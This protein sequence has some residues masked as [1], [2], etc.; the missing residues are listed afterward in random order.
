MNQERGALLSIYAETPLHAGSGTGLGAVDLPI[1]RE[2]MSGLPM[3][4]GSGIKGALYHELEHRLGKPEC[5]AL[6][7]P[8]PDKKDG[9]PPDYAGALSISDARLMLF[10]ARTVWGGWAWLTSPMI[11]ERLVR[12]LRAVGLE[13]SALEDA[14]NQAWMEGEHGDGDAIV[15][16][17]S[18]VAPKGDLFIED[19]VY[20]AVKS[21]AVDTLAKWI[22]KHVFPHGDEPLR[23]DKPLRS[24]EYRPFRDR[25]SG[26]LAIVSDAELR[27]LSKQATEV[28]ARIRIAPE[29]GTVARG[30]LWSEEHLPAE[31]V[32]W[33][34]AFVSQD[35]RP[36]DK[37]Q[38]N[39]KQRGP[40]DLLQALE[41]SVNSAGRIR[42]G[43]D[44]TVGRGVAAMRML[45]SVPTAPPEKQP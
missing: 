1:Q 20:H 17:N 35:R 11:L 27:E 22:G 34:T 10:P 28:V 30:A 21:A 32:L 38:S 6:F 14:R 36:S 15:G 40:Q 23:D 12:D 45:T 25:L 39:D 37:R 2:R 31:S 3:M 13:T 4:Q 41:S 8:R 44:R 9:E 29:T 19:F 18:A 5:A 16:T 26:Q 7:G 42:L 24:D 33:C 43:G